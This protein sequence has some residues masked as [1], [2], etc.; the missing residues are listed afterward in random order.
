[1][2]IFPP[3]LSGPVGEEEVVKW[4]VGGEERDENIRGL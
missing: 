2:L 4:V 1:M 3:P